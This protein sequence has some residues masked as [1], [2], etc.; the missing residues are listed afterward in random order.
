MRTT[1]VKKISRCLCCCFRVGPIHCA[2]AQPFTMK[3]RLAK[4][5]SFLPILLFAASAAAQ[6]Y[7]YEV[8]DG[9]EGSDYWY[10][11]EFWKTFLSVIIT[12]VA[13]YFIAKRQGDD[14]DDGEL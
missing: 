5:A 14:F 9:P 12:F 8:V 7:N 4:L 10:K 3:H 11:N 1:I 6:N 2:R 13:P